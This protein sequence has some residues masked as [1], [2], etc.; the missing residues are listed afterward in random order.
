MKELLKK[1]VFYKLYR[2]GIALKNNINAVLHKSNNTEDYYCSGCGKNW[3]SF[4]PFPYAWF[5]MLKDAGW[6]YELEDA[7]TLNYKNYS[8]Y[9]C[10]I[11]DRDRLYLLYFKN[12]L[13]K[14][15]I[16]NIV[17]FAPTPVLSSFFKKYNNINHRTSDLFM[18]NVDD[19]MDLQDLFLYKNAQFDIFICS[20]ILEHVP[21]DIKAMKELYRITKKGGFG[22]AMVPIL[23][24]V[25]KTHED[26][27]IKDPKLRM[28]YFGQGDHVRL[29]AKNDFIAR[30]E[31]VGFKVRLL[32]EDY[33]GKEVFYKNAITPA[34]VL[35]IVEKV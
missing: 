14:E 26:P 6:K 29:Y 31:S 10:G 2:G 25:E 13:N 3:K 22:I 5:K 33:F 27:S 11:N 19:K 32:G 9:G 23:N 28:K 15:K 24:R 18:D 8:C 21:E 4:K 1:T 30:L 20:H 16:Y 7:E 12:I 35:Y 17:E 34:S